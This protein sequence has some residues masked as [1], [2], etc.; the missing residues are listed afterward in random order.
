MNNP[1]IQ[2]KKDGVI[3]KIEYAQGLAMLAYYPLEHTCQFLPS[4]NPTRL[5]MI[6]E[7]FTHKNWIL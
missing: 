3:A 6:R 4:S 2:E 7:R 1:A 5:K